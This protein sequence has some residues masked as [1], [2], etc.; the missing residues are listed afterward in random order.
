M[1]RVAPFLFL[2]VACNP[3]KAL[4]P[5][6]ADFAAGQGPA[7]LSYKV[8]K[9]WKNVRSETDS[10]G[11]PVK[12][13]DYGGGT[14]FYVA[15]APKGGNIQPIPRDRHVPRLL[16]SGDTLYKEQSEQTG[17]IWREDVKGALRAGYINVKEGTSEALFDSAVNSVK[18]FR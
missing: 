9:G 6:T 11:R 7:A 10:A 3:Y 12:L 4:R 2:L 8:P 1:K 17:R 5:A 14:V 18:A 13:Y 16:P 15:Y